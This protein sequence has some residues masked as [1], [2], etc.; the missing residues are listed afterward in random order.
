MYISLWRNPRITLFSLL[1]RW[2]HKVGIFTEYHSVCTLVASEC[3]PPPGTKRGGGTLACSQGLGESQFRRLEKRLST[4]PTLWLASDTFDLYNRLRVPEVCA[5]IK[6]FQDDSRQRQLTIDI[7]QPTHESDGKSLKI[8]TNDRCHWQQKS[9]S[10]T[11]SIDNSFSK[12]FISFAFSGLHLHCI[13][14][15]ILTVVLPKLF[16]AWSLYI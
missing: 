6:N 3:A 11:M 13:S 2:P 5:D 12:I 16:Q 4:L 14:H 10:P 9:I 15:V 7:Q 8:T 1:Y